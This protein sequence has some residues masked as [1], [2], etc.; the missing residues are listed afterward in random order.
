M[1]NVQNKPDILY[2]QYKTLN[3]IA[4]S[5]YFKMRKGPAYIMIFM[6]TL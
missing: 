2:P 5:Y 6:Y 3:S 4:H 1:N